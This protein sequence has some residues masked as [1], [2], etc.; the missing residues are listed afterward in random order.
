V[1]DPA[2]HARLTALH[3]RLTQPTPAPLDGQQTID[4]TQPVDTQDR[5]SDGPTQPPLPL[6]T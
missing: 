1:T 2:V 4:D 6:W 5:P 3:D